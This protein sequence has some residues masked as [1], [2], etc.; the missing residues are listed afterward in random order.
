MRVQ[1]LSPI[2]TPD[3]VQHNHGE[4]IDVAELTP[5]Q[6]Q[7]VHVLEDAPAV[8]PPASKAGTSTKEDN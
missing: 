8:L 7:S 1:V 2:V 6:L 4:V 5:L 3:G